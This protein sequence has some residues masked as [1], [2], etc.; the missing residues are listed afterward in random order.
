MLQRSGVGSIRARSAAKAGPDE[1]RESVAEVERRHGHRIQRVAVSMDIHQHLPSRLTVIAAGLTLHA[2]RL[3]SSKFGLSAAEWR[4]IVSLGQLAPI[5][6]NDLAR[7]IGMDRAGV[8]RTIESLQKRGYIER[9]T[10]RADRRQS[11]LFLTKKG[12][13]VHDKIAPL[14][15]AREKRLTSV[16]SKDDLAKL[17]KM[18]DTLQEEVDRMLDET[19]PD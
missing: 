10:D 16:L 14:A 5:S 6:F 12:V 13:A 7:N 3:Y 8:S 4:I 1:V 2:Y 15:R 17:Y 9:H 19:T 11:V 18:L